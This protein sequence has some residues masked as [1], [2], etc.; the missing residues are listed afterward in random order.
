MQS[1][2]RFVAALAL[3]LGACVGVVGESGGDPATDPPPGSAP[4]GST[5]PGPGAPMAPPVGPSRP[6]APLRRLSR[7]QYNNTVRDLLGDSSRPADAFLVEEIPGS[8]AGS[9]ALA[10]ASPA[11]VEQYRTAAERLATT[12]V[13]N[14][15]TLLPCQPQPATEESCAR[16]FIAD[17]GL[18]A[19]RRP[20]TDQ[21]LAGLLDVYRKVRVEGD[22]ALGIQA[23][24]GALLQSSSFL[25]RVELPPPGAAMGSVAPLGPYEL[26]SRLSYFLLGSMPDAALFTAAKAGKLA[27]PADLEAQARRLLALPRARD[28]A[29]EF[30]TQWLSLANLEGQTKDARLFPAFNDTLRAAM[31]EETVRFTR[32]AL[33]D[34]D[35]R[36]DTL[37][38]S[39]RSLVNATL[40]KLYG[41]TGGADYTLTDLPAG[42]RSGL[43]THASLLTLTA[44]SDSTSPTRRGKFVLDQVLCQSPPPPP[45]NVDFKLPPPMPGQSAR[46][47]FAAHTTNPACAGCHVFIDPIGFGFE[48]YD[49]IGR[50]QATDGGQPVDASGEIK[51]SVDVDGPFVGAVA[52]GRKL[53]GSNQVRRCLV[54]QWFSYAHGRPDE[55]GDA[56]SVAEALDRFVAASGDVRELMVALVK[57][58]AFRSLVVEVPR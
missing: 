4:P 13:T 30:F 47:R 31:R 33:F 15:A 10:Q 19:L 35:G 27:T 55:A 53:V 22:F 23:V 24:I 37:L 45:P 5:P 54:Q 40:A 8:F 12:A 7:A 43:L 20:P 34:A 1:D 18:R 11:A 17:F 21:E 48:S 6:K 28:N 41:V 52:L 2:V 51:G 25:Y 56:A 16:A 50:F 42:Q 3:A 9:A 39:P 32:W 57:T 14:L 49:A 44:H 26:A 36:L 29:T 58:P 46:Q 38:T